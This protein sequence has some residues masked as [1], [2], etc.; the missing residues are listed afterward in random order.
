MNLRPCRSKGVRVR[1]QNIFAVVL[2]TICGASAG[3]EEAPNQP[4][5]TYN[6]GGDTYNFYFQ[7]APG[8][9]VVNQGG[10]ASAEEKSEGLPAAPTSPK[11]LPEGSPSPASG[12]AP[13]KGQDSQ[14]D[15]RKWELYLGQGSQQLDERY[16]ERSAYSMANAMAVG[17]GYRWNSYVGINAQLTRANGKEDRFWDSAESGDRWLPRML[18]TGDS[19]WLPSLMLAITPLRLNVFGKDL[20]DFTFEGGVGAGLRDTEAGTLKVGGN[21]TV[22]LTQALALQ[23]RVYSFNRDTRYHESSFG[24]V[25]RP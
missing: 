4:G 7:K 13:E 22:N 14:A 2:F 25:W 12:T 20:V 9:S 21:I 19:V 1:F 6:S 8:P 16:A 17:I 24:L 15:F 5:A 18:K 3:A 11:S 10:K 23:G